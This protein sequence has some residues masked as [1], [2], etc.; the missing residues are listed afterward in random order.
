MSDP[1]IWDGL[2]APS[3]YGRY[4]VEYV[5]EEWAA[6]LEQPANGHFVIIGRGT[7]ADHHAAIVAAKAC[8]QAD[9]D[10]RA[11]SKGGAA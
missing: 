6:L 3:A 10:R 11:A 8:A 4:E 7:A 1:L 9:H 5:G 2:T